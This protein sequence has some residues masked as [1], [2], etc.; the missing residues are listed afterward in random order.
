MSISKAA[1]WLA[2]AGF[3]AVFAFGLSID[4]GFNID[5]SNLG[6][7]IQVMIADLYVGFL[8]FAIIIFIVEPNKLKALCWCAPLFI[9]GNGV[10]AVW[11]ILNVDKIRDRF[12]QN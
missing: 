2:L 8:L 1:A 6:I 10:S 4:P 9:L 12:T 7:W 11:L 3:V 5:F